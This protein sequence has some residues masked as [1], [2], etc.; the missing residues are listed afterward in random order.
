[1]K[2][3]VPCLMI[4]ALVLATA[5]VVPTAA[6][7]PRGCIGQDLEQVCSTPS[8]GPCSIAFYDLPGRVAWFGVNCA[9]GPVVLP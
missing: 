1:M 6:A 2:P 7:E 3:F 5:A 4:G 8:G 9:G